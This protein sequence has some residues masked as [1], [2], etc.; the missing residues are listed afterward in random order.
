MAALV[1]TKRVSG[2]FDVEIS[3][4]QIQKSAVGLTHFP[5]QQD[6]TIRF[7][8]R[9]EKGAQGRKVFFVVD[10]FRPDNAVK[11]ACQCRLQPI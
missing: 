3:L 7:Q 6:F 4:H 9:F 1:G 10:Q 2:D 5:G 8:E 11:A